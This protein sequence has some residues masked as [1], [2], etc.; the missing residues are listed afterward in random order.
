M[1]DPLRRFRNLKARKKPAS[2]GE[3]I[4][5]KFFKK[6]EKTTGQASKRRSRHASTRANQVG[7]QPSFSQQALT[8]K[9]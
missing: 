6:G 2:G 5:C 9:T 3:Q 7:V 4:D 1:K 8:H